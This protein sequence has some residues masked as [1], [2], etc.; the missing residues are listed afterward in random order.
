MIRRPP[1]STLFPYTT[2]FRA[3][4]AKRYIQLLEENLLP[5]IAEH[6]LAEF[7]DVFCDRGAFSAAES[8]RVLQAGGQRGLA[9]PIHE[10]GRAHALNPV[11][12]KNRIPAFALKK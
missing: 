7:C 11:T 1:R 6:R 3:D 8:K 9:P 10:I 12:T 4:G 5:T 2:L